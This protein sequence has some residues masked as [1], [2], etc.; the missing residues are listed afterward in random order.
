MVCV[1]RLSELESLIDAVMKDKGENVMKVVIAPDS[2]KG[3]VSS[4][5]AAS[6]IEQSIKLM[7]EGIET[8][9]IPMAD[10]G[11][12]T[13]DAF[14]AIFG[15]ERIEE[16]VED[17]LGREISAFYGWID[18]DQ[19]A[20]IETAAASGLPLL[21]EEE[22]NPYQASTYGT[23][24][25]IKSALN[26]GA[27]KIIVGLG[28]SATVDAGTGCLQALGVRF[29][30]K[31]GAELR[32]CGENL[33]NIYSIDDSKLDARL[34]NTEIIVASDVMN[35]L[36]G[37]NGAVY[38]FGPQ[39]GV[40]E[41]E[42]PIFEEYMSHYA[43]VVIQTVQKDETNSPGSGAAGGFGFSLQS[44][45]SIQMM[46]GFELIAKLSLL[47]EHIKEAD[48]VITGEGKF[49]SQSLYG[50]VPIGIARIAKKYYTPVVVF[51][52]NIED[53][54][55]SLESQGISLIY[56]IVDGIMT[57]QEAM[58]NGCELI[59]RT[60]RRFFKAVQI[61]YSIKKEV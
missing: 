27:K 40:K 23:G 55:D 3:S 35:P 34:R 21:K 11:E 7:N 57:L 25:L 61:G 50:K 24:Q 48:L 45:L 51:A 9:M 42:L 19:T 56:P 33:R 36:L 37:P 38:V 43:T 26:K 2:F 5:K 39:K 46:S 44:F 20:I 6:L 15:G 10:G 58:E 1:A 47:E 60:T 30:D 32:A 13:V 59:K 49:D 18:R 41:H 4:T 22:L 53:N 17:P 8:V 29:L 16:T 28:G 14:L 54:L 31:Q 52:G 12:G